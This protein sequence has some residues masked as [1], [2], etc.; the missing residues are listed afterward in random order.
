[1]GKVCDR[2]DELAQQREALGFL[3][4][5]ELTVGFLE[6][7]L[8]MGLGRY[9]GQGSR[10]ALRLGFLVRVHHPQY[11]STNRSVQVERQSSAET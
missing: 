11:G 8:K 7:E 5:W 4:L 2:L 10:P 1:M 6:V 3:F 9:W